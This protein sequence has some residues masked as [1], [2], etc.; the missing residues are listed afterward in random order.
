MRLHQLLSS[1]PDHPLCMDLS[2]SHRPPSPRLH[3]V[4]LAEASSLC[5][6]CFPPRFFLVSSSFP[7]STLLRSQTRCCPLPLSFTHL[8]SSTPPLSSCLPSPSL[9]KLALPGSPAPCAA[10]VCSDCVP[11]VHME[12]VPPFQTH[13]FPHLRPPRPWLGGRSLALLAGERMKIQPT[14]SEAQRASL[15]GSLYS[16]PRPS[17]TPTSVF[18]LSSEIRLHVVN[19]TYTAERLK[20]TEYENWEDPGVD[21]LCCFQTFPPQKNDLTCYFHTLIF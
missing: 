21:D 5:W 20:K 2:L 9:A 6:F 3:V 19:I 16:S 10:A 1:L 13:S 17:V 8:H 7:L 14:S 18:P 4:T 11:A 12:S 15:P